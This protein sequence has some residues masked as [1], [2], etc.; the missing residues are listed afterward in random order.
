MLEGGKPVAVATNTGVTDLARFA[1]PVE[2]QVQNKSFD[3]EV[4]FYVIRKVKAS[5]VSR[6]CDEV[7]S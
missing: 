5:E 7:A 4:S 3:K 6:I 2:K 1:G